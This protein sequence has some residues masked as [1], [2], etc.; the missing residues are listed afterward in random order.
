MNFSAHFDHK[1]ILRIQCASFKSIGDD[2]VEAAGEG[3]GESVGI[4]LNDE[5]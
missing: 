1:L 4:L 2:I 5:Y 3:G